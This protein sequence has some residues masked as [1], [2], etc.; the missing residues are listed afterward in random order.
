MLCF[1]AVLLLLSTASLFGQAISGDIVGVVTDSTGAAVPN[2]TVTAT[3]KDTNV[4]NTAETNAAGEYRLSNL[5]VGRYDVSATAKGFATATIAN[6]EA[7]LNHVTTANVTLP[8]G[9]VTTTVEVTEAAALIDTSTAQLQTTFESKQSVEQPLAGITRAVGGVS[10]IY[11]LSFI[12]AGV[13]SSGG[14]GQGTGPSISGQRPENNS[15]TLDGVNND[16]RYSTGPAMNVS[17]E[18]IAQLNILQNQFSA[19]RDELAS[20]LYLRVLP[21]S[22]S[23]RSGCAKRDCRTDIPAALRQQPFGRHCGR[24]DHQGQAVLLRKL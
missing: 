8:V 21:E 10:G 2:A 11:N 14:V 7:Q 20:R 19:D 6:V 18:A 23:E 12:G 24:T 3:N 17:N 1:L 15:F 4:K 13:A 22:R 9:S 16:D 5:P